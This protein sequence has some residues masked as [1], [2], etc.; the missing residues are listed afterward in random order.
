MG[1]KSL[2]GLPKRFS[3]IFSVLIV[4]TRSVLPLIVKGNDEKFHG[5]LAGLDVDDVANENFKSDALFMYHAIEEV[6]VAEVELAP[7]SL[8]V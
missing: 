5:S 1:L 4:A 7:I 6:A 2:R 3:F 8:K